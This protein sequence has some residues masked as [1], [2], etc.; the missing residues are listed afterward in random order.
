MR[1]TKTCDAI[2]ELAQDAD[3]LVHECTF[4]ES[5]ARMAASYHHSTSRQTAQ[6]AQASNVKALYLTHISARYM[7][8]DAKQLEDQARR[9]FE[10]ARSSNYVVRRFHI[11]WN[12]VPYQLEQGSISSGTRFHIIWNKA[13]CL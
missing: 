10:G 11:N 4:E 6:V 3:A 5:E 9:I 13:S 12:R 1:D 2:Q 8:R 7:G